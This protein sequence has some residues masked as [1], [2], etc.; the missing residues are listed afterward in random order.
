MAREVAHSARKAHSS[1]LPTCRDEARRRDKSGWTFSS[2]WCGSVLRQAYGVPRWLLAR[3]RRWLLYLAASLA[4]LGTFIEIADEVFEDEEV[5]L[6]DV[7]IMRAVSNLRLPWLTLSFV[8]LTA[9][10][11]LTLLGLVTACSTVALL[12]MRD[13]R[14]ALQLISAVFGAGV[15]TLTTKSWFARARPDPLHRLIEVQGYSFPSGHS[16]GSAA[17]YIT[18]ALV[19]GRHLRTLRSRSILLGGS[20]TFAALIGLSRVYLGVH[21][22]SDV[23]SGLAFGTGWALLLTAAFELQEVRRQRALALRE[24]N[25][26]QREGSR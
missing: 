26:G 23:A 22:P 21:Y 12:R 11:S 25:H 24:R 18:L 9:L 20:V 2:G 6:L 16:A 3:E 4:A 15:W 10:G 1:C 7:R 14:G 17:L 19:F 5:A 13:V 8:D